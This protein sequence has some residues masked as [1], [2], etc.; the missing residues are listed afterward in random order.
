MRWLIILVVIGFGCAWLTA[1]GLDQG[2]AVLDEAVALRE[3]ERQRVERTFAQVAEEGRQVAAHAAEEGR[4]LTAQVDEVVEA[5]VPPPPPSKPVVPAAPVPTAD[6][7]GQTPDVVERRLGSPTGRT[8][9][10]NGTE[11]WW[12]DRRV[13]VFRDRRVIHIR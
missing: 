1:R 9:P 13:V 7:I 4:Q 10:G 11:E 8:R 6:L 3:R 5:V 2:V 12:Y